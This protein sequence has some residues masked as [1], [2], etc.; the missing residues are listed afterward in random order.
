MPTICIT[1][2]LYGI[3]IKFIPI[4]CNDLVFHNI[5]TKTNINSFIAVEQQ[6]KYLISVNPRPRHIQTRVVSH[7][8]HKCLRL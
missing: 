2:A 7:T 4:S 3:Q 1:L 8:F 6:E 5:L